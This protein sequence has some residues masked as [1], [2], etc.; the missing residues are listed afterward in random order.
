MANIEELRSARLAKLENIKK[1]GIW[2]YPLWTGRTNTI[3]EVF[4]DWDGLVKSEK[5]VVLAGRMKSMRGHGGL[6]FVDVED[7]SG[8]IQAFFKKDGLG[9][10]SYEFFC[11]NF[12]IGDFIEVRGILFI[13][14]RGE[15]TVD[16][17]DYKMLSKSLLP[18]PEKW[19]GLQDAEERYRKRYLDLIFNSEVKEKLVI[20]TKI[21]TAIRAFL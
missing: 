15:K 8:K 12:D 7:G 21:I 18:L 1:A 3:G 13:T 19:H 10:K 16:V 6:T 9:E 11:D 14:K 4:L 20:R 2:A 17:R 5:E